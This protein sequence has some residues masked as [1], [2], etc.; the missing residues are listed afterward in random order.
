MYLSHTHLMD[1]NITEGLELHMKMELI[2]NCHCQTM[3]NAIAACNSLVLGR[4]KPATSRTVQIDIYEALLF[5]YGS[6]DGVWIG[7]LN[8]A[9]MEK[10]YTKYHLSYALSKLSS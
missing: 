3:M 1:T 5:F 4:E 9:V 2:L 10:S 8:C 6:S 7:N